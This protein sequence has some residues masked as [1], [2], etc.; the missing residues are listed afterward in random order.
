MD[1]IDNSKPI[2]QTINKNV[3]NNKTSSTEQLCPKYR[4]IPSF[5]H[6]EII[7][8]AEK[9]EELEEEERGEEDEIRNPFEKSNSLENIT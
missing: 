4:R 3:I 6:N 9:L 8:T 2:A 7:K 1:K 5:N